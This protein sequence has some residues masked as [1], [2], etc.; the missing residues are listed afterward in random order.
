M[1]MK[2]GFLLIACCCL[3]SWKSL[4]QRNMMD[5][6]IAS[7]LLALQYSGTASEGDLKKRF[8]YFN[9][10]GIATGY[11]TQHNWY[12]GITGNFLFGNQIK[13]SHNQLFGHLMDKYGL[14]TSEIGHPAVIVTFS[15]GIDCNVEIGKV[16]NKLGHNS[17]SGLFVKIGGGYINHRIRI[18]S[19]EDLVPLLEKEYRKGYDRYTAGIN[20]S[21]F[22]GYLFLPNRGFT[23][24]YAGFYIQEGFTKNK[25]TI[26]FDKP[27]QVV[28]TKLRIDIL[29]G[30]KVGWLIPIY[31]RMPREYYY[32]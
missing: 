11:K 14:I 22:I 24:F 7:P 4:S 16:F 27:D 30:F 5:S 12:V 2:N 19:N 21:Q 13:L 31:R 17:N 15:R 28:S 23:N 8:G 18:E 29:Y 26:F 10:V 3:L 32:D 1:V 6:V 9:H 25:R 20:I